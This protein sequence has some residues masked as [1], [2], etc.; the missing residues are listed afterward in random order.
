MR[1]LKPLE[2]IKPFYK[3]QHFYLGPDKGKSSEIFK[4]N[5]K[6]ISLLIRF[7]TGHGFLRRHEYIVAHG[8]YP[9]SGWAA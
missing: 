9:P 3:G 4:L 8:A 1:L 6:E 7:L 2:D 5:R